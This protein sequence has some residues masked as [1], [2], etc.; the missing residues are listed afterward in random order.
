MAPSKAN[1]RP[2]ATDSAASDLAAA[3]RVLSYASDA[4]LSLS[5]SL[6]GD[7]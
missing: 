1:M 2:L 5:R 4:L 6:D 7:F 3:Q